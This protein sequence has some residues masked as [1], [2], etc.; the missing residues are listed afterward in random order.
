MISSGCSRAIAERTTCS[1]SL[2]SLTFRISTALAAL[3]CSP[4]PLRCICRNPRGVLPSL[5]NARGSET[6]A[7]PWNRLASKLHRCAPPGKLR[8]ASKHLLLLFVLCR[9]V[10]GGIRGH[11]KRAGARAPHEHPQERS[12]ENGLRRDGRQDR[13]RRHRGRRAVGG[14][15]LASEGGAGRQGCRHPVALSARSAARARRE[16]VPDLARQG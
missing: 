16:V 7:K 8:S 15:A 12:D 1:T 11:R 13:E 3:F 2:A 14:G 6:R 10:E 4:R 5:L 9:T